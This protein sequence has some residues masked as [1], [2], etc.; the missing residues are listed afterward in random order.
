MGHGAELRVMEPAG[1]VKRIAK[2]HKA[3]AKQYK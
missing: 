2:A 3:A 1:L